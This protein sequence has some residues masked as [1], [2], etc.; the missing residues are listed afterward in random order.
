M[1]ILEMSIGYGVRATMKRFCSI[2]VLCVSFT[3]QI[4]KT[5]MIR[6]W[7]VADPNTRDQ[8]AFCA[9]HSFLVEVQANAVYI[10]T[11][12]I[13]TWR[14]GVPAPLVACNINLYL[15]HSRAQCTNDIGWVTNLQCLSDF[16][17]GCHVNVKSQ[18]NMTF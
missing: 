10:L 7:K 8:I 5:H 15:H 17:H 14:I 11:Y 2:A 12:V 3:W 1:Y 9:F 18:T 6:L 4:V 16:W 13:T